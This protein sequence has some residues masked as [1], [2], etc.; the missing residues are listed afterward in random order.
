MIQWMKSRAVGIA[1][2]TAGLLMAAT[3]LTPKNSVQAASYAGM[4]VPSLS[5]QIEGADELAL[6][7]IGGGRVTA[8]SRATASTW[9]V[10]VNKNGQSQNVW[11][12]LL[13]G[14]VLK[15][16]NGTASPMAIH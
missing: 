4:R 1:A 9:V 7:A 15:M 14:Q 6:Q 11:V 13:K 10:T 12:N 5:Q 3:A 16:V 8:I 2:L